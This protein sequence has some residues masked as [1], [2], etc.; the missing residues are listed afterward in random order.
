MDASVV[1][2]GWTFI[3]VI[4]IGIIVICSFVLAMRRIT[5]VDKPI[6]LIKTIA[7]LVTCIGFVVGCVVGRVFKS[8]TL[9]YVWQR[10]VDVLAFLHIDELLV[11]VYLVQHFI[12]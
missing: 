8:L 10:L 6:V 3:N 11:V 5:R 4:R 7:G 9:A 2:V 12:I 1:G